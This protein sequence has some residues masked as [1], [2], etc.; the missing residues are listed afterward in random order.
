MVPGGLRLGHDQPVLPAAAL[1]LV[2][3]GIVSVIT[4]PVAGPVPV[5][6]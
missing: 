2:C 5:F 1:N 3:C 4:T 6:A